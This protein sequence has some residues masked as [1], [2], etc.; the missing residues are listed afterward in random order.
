MKKNKFA[1]IKDFEK[2][3]DDFNVKK[4]HRQIINYNHYFKLKKFIE[5]K[6]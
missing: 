6:T 1:M 3:D 5:I 2:R 4:T